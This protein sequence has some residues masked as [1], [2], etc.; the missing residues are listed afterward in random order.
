MES[1]PGFLSLT[2]TDRRLAQEL[3]YGVMRQ[4]STLDW[5]I[6]RRTAGRPQ[7][8]ALHD[9]LRLGLYQLFFLDRVPA[10]AAVHETVELAR[11][12]G[13]PQQS[14]FV[15]A[16]LRGCDRDRQSL[17]QEIEQLKEADPAV[18]WS[19]P[20]WLVDRWRGRFGKVGLR[21]MLEWDNSPPPTF[22]RVNTLRTTPEQL[23]ERWK[24]EGVVGVAVDH[25]WIAAGHAFHLQSHPPL[26]GLGSFIEGGFYVQDPSTLLAVRELDPQPGD[27]VLDFCAAP[28]GKT[29]HIAQLLC[30]QG[31]V[32]AH[33]NSSSRLRL[34]AENCARLGVTCV[35][36]VSPP[37]SPGQ[38]GSFDRVLLDAPCS[39]T[40]V[41]RRRLELRW[42]I[43]A[44][45]IGRLAETQC[46]LL[47]RV[48]TYVR[49]GGVLVYSTCS[50]ESEENEA[51][52]AAFSGADR[53]FELVRQ[54]H[55]DPVH[56][57]V[58]GAYVAVLRRR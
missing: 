20:A 31:R 19:H 12:A 24:T 51:V 55:L 27:A 43:R 4:R 44:E 21:K 49:P 50:L 54:R 14:G 56:D 5:I 11:E 32:I 45:E 35:E 28:G 29:T 16:V 40:G 33:D 52:T 23:Q 38:P 26:A 30:N 34:V 18:A 17:R 42:R 41:L 1:D 7:K 53:A 2:A 6:H 3:V 48:A 57:R 8:P 22:V 25:D 47:E 39:N 10:H 13:F 37:A 58:D 15:N 36:A 9:L 46:R